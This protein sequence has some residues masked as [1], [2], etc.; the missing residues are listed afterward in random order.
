MISTVFCAANTYRI[1]SET[2][3]LSR[4]T[5]QKD[6]TDSLQNQSTVAAIISSV[7]ATCLQITYPP[8]AGI[9]ERMNHLYIAVN[10]FWLLSLSLSVSCALWSQLASRWIVSA[11][12]T[13]KSRSI[14][15][16]V[17]RI[18]L[19]L[20][21]TSSLA[22]AC[23]LICLAFSVFPRI[24]VIPIVTAIVTVLAAFLCLLVGAW[25]YVESSWRGLVTWFKGQLDMAGSSNSPC[26]NSSN[27]TDR[28]GSRVVFWSR[29]D[30]RSEDSEA[31]IGLSTYPHV[32]STWI[33][34]PSPAHKT[35]P[36]GKRKCTYV[37]AIRMLK[38]AI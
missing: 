33:V 23:G 24:I 5:S 12:H 28:L 35:L 16:W 17:L 6:R 1:R 13:G 10:F 37:M 2:H 30:E 32:F 27:T 8:P 20:L 31:N 19:F 9:S 7:T 14:S 34:E 29:K 38:E 25:L 11:F 36:H 22:F 15:Q 4:R 26:S 18:P 3:H 21:S